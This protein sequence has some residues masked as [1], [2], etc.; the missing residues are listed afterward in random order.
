MHGDHTEAHPQSPKKHRHIVR[1]PSPCTSGL[2]FGH[3]GDAL[4]QSSQYWLIAHGLVRRHQWSNDD[5]TKLPSWA[6]NLRMKLP[7]PPPPP[8]PPI[9]SEHL[10]PPNEHNPHTPTANFF[11]L[12]VPNTSLFQSSPLFAWHTFNYFP[13]HIRSINTQQHILSYSCPCSRHLN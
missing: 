11:Q 10:F 4:R 6:F 1:S 3:A 8:P 5:N 13:P 12:P 9:P 7:P 2:N